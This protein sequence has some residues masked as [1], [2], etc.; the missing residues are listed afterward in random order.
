MSIYD[1]LNKFYHKKTLERSWDDRSGKLDE[2]QIFMKFL[3]NED[4]LENI[5]FNSFIKNFK[6]LEGEVDES[7]DVLFFENSYQITHGNTANLSKWLSQKKYQYK[8]NFK[9]TSREFASGVL[10]APDVALS[11][12]KK[13]EFYLDDRIIKKKENT[14]NGKIILLVRIDHRDFDNECEEKIVTNTG[15]KNIIFVFNNKNFYLKKDI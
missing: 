4:I 12:C 11:D 3:E 13:I 2:I 15:W 9:K 7:G 1:K 14:S 8:E 10:P 6:Y 5:D